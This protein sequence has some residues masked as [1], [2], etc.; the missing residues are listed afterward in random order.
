MIFLKKKNKLKLIK[1]IN[2]IKKYFK[3]T[4]TIIL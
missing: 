2:L 4:E 3:N 1:I